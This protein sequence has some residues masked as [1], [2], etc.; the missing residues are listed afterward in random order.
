MEKALDELNLKL[1]DFVIPGGVCMKCGG[2]EYT[3]RNVV[4]CGDCELRK[5]QDLEKN[6]R[7]KHYE[8][9]NPLDEYYVEKSESKDK[10]NR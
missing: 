7:K 3:I 5:K 2:R 10:K 8:F 4:H 1:P 6:K 9:G